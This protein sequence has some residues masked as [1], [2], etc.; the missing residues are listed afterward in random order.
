MQIVANTVSSKTNMLRVLPQITDTMQEQENINIDVLFDEVI[1]PFVTINTDASKRQKDFIVEMEQ[2]YCDLSSKNLSEYGNVVNDIFSLKTAEE[3]SYI[4]ALRDIMASLPDFAKMLDDD[5]NANTADGHNFNVFKLLEICHVKIDET[6]Q[7]RILKFLLEPNEMHE[8]GNLFLKLFLKRLGISV[9]DDFNKERWKV[10]REDGQVDLL[11][12]RE[13]PLAVVVIEN[14]SNWAVDRP[15]QLYRYWHYAIYSR[16]RETDGGFYERENV[17]FR[18]V[19]LAPNDG[20]MPSAQTK[21][22][23]PYF[24]KKLPL[25]LPMKV[26]VRTFDG[27]IYQWLED[28][29]QALPPTNHAL[30]EFLRQYQMKC[31]TL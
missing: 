2:L 10:D 6:N 23:P 12:T 26:D 29:K 15:N 18:V 13:S 30:R 9:S 31:K 17:R 16:T 28:C 4:S 14:K 7:S 21:E 27:F 3:V 5:R 24:P 11:L 1:N 19:Y 22:R 20:K 25:T 8:Q